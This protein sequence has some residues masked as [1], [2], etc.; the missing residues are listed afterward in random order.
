MMRNKM[1]YVLGTGLLAGL[2][3]SFFFKF[4]EQW[5]AVKVYT[6][7]LNVDYIPFL[8][9]FTFPEFVEVGFHLIVSVF[10][11]IGLFFM[12]QKISS[13]QYKL[14]ASTAVNLVI[15]ALYFPVT[16]LSDRTPSILDGIAFAYWLTGH[17]LYGLLLGY[18]LSRRIAA[19]R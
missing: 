6:L 14:F 19:N 16:A 7:L 3:L 13:F 2:A 11:S 10:I 18:L 9:R 1:A 4:I 15:G 8:N 5:T 17:V 12:L